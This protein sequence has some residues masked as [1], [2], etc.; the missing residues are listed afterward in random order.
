MDR[1]EGGRNGQVDE[2][3]A[4]RRERRRKRMKINNPC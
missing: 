4:G 2:G 1:R 3:K